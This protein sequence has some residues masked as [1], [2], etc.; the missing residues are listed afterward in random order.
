MRPSDYL[1]LS[2]GSPPPRHPRR[3]PKKRSSGRGAVVGIVIAV[4][5]A[6]L[7]LVTTV[8]AASA[9][10]AYQSLTRDLP[11]VAGV[12]NRPSFKTTRVLD[13]NGNLIYELFD[14]DKGKR[15]VVHV[16]DLPKQMVGAVLAVEDST[17]Y[18]NPGVE[19]RGIL[20]AVLQDVA[21]GTIV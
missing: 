12:G 3:S 4:L 9:Y 18:D 6:V 16:G 14:P 5:A 17:F 21:S 7:G 15:T 20:R 2:S 19:W 13:R 10:S 1:F 11:S 8:G